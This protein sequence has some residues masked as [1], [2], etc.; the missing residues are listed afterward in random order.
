MHA[1]HGFHG[2]YRPGEVRFLLEPSAV[3]TLAVPDKERLIQSGARHYSEMLSPE[4]PPSAAYLAA[5]ETAFARNRARLAGDLVGLAEALRDQVGDGVTVVS[6]ARA[7]TP[8]GVLLFH[9][10]RRLGV[11]DVAH[12]SVSIVRDKG[13]DPVALAWILER[14]DPR[15]VRFVDGW[16]GKGVIA[17]ELR[18]SLAELAGRGLALPRPELWVVADLAGVADVCASR[19]DYLLPSAILGGTVSG[20]VSRS[21]WRG[22]LAEQ[23]RFHLCLPL[24]HL[25]EHDLSARFVDEVL[26][27]APPA[28]PFRALGPDSGEPARLAMRRALDGLAARHGVRDLNLLK[29]GIGEATRALLRRLS[30]RLLLAEGEDPDTDHLRLLAAER[31]IEVEPLGD[32]PFRAAALIRDLRE[33]T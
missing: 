21:V 26:A 22:G 1:D 25:R 29:P 17:D 28:A 32:A 31:G 13:L 5:F 8:I 2:S 14:R 15:G 33:T 6:L 19:D 24:E 4:R 7:G 27:A 10:L 9:L 20:L 12:C 11:A 23:G 3:P 16:T 30:G 18:R